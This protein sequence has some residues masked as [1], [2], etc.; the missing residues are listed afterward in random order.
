MNAG[1]MGGKNFSDKTE[2]GVTQQFAV[3]VLGH[4][5]LAEGLLE[6]KKLTKVAVYAGSE[7][8]RGVPKM[9]IKRPELNTSTVDE[10]ASICD[11]SFIANTND[12]LVPYGPVKYVTALWMSSIAREVSRHLVCH[13]ESRVNQWNRCRR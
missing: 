1:G 6:A 7:A 5:V 8:A 9:R 3:N 4:V 12:P 10:F 11:G 2:Y 13:D